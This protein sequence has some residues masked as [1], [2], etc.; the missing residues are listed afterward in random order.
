MSSTVSP[1]SAASFSEPVC[2]LGGVC[3]DVKDTTVERMAM[4]EQIEETATELT[5]SAR[6]DLFTEKP[7]TGTPLL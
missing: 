7:K 5:A 2:V 1:T 6:D 4:G 3:G